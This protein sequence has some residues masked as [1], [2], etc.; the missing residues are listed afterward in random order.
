MKNLH[1]SKFLCIFAR[2]IINCEYILII[3]DYINKEENLHS[4]T[5]RD[6]GNHTAADALRQRRYSSANLRL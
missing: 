6:R 5:H 2:F 1:M 4:A 3:F